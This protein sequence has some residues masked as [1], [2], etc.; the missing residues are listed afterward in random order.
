MFRK[1]GNG[2]T[3]GEGER[4]KGIWACFCSFLVAAA[5]TV[6]EATI[7]TSLKN[8]V[9]EARTAHVESGEAAEFNDKAARKEAGVGS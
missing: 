8:K 3:R 6:G 9:K 2:N 7:M 1:Q 5:T 4:G